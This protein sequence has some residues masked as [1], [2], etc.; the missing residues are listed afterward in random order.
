MPRQ[1]NKDKKDKPMKSLVIAFTLAASVFAKTSYA[2]DGTI[3]PAVLKSFEATFAT[4]TE[5]DWTVTEDLY[6]AHFLMDGQ[7]ITAFYRTDGTMAAFTRNI[8][9]RQ[10]PVTLQASLKHDYKEYWVSGLFELSNDEGVQY[11]ITV[12]NAD[13]KLVLKAMGSNWS[14]FQKTRKN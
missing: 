12:E 8:S 11:Y 3:T 5:V 6:K 4:A 7:H 9:V 14:P 2:N 10:L 1:N 13:N